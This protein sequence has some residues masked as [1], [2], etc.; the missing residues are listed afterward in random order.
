M[1]ILVASY[2]L[3]E[4]SRPAVALRF[5]CDAAARWAHL[6]HRLIQCRL[7]DDEEK[8]HCRPREKRSL[9]LFL[10]CFGL[11][12]S[13]LSGKWW[14]NVRIY[15]HD[16][17]NVIFFTVVTCGFTFWFFFRPQTT[18]SFF[19]FRYFHHW[20]LIPTFGVY[21]SRAIY[22]R[23]ALCWI[24]LNQQISNLQTALSNRQG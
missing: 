21:C 17:R 6:Q 14:M 2:G 24:C 1:S 4:L 18:V 7:F 19:L 22:C 20:H 5:I 3:D 12:S 16:E 10:T 15:Q 11:Y 8:V 9:S 23:P 13:C